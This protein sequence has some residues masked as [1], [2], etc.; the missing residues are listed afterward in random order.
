M[1]SFCDRDYLQALLDVE[2]ALAAAAADLRTSF[3]HRA[4]AIFAPPREPIVT[5]IAALDG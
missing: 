2:V 5:T 4:S 1:A 3:P